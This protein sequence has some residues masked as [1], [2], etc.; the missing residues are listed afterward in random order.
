MKA[1]RTERFLNMINALCLDVESIK[2]GSGS[3][4]EKAAKIRETKEIYK[5]DFADILEA[6]Q[7]SYK[8]REINPAPAESAILNILAMKKRGLT[9]AE[10]E[11][12]AGQVQSIQGRQRL[13]RIAARHGIKT[14][15]AEEVIEVLSNYDK[16]AKYVNAILSTK[17]PRAFTSE[18]ELFKV[19]E[20][21]SPERFKE[22][23]NIPA[24]EL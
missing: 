9:V 17:E 4:E 23:V 1:P 24:E 19:L 6:M 3:G 8:A 11:E 18:K 20:I 16:I 22:Y 15:Y 5:Y 2:G 14:K 7:E 12:A 10:L 13:D 21:T